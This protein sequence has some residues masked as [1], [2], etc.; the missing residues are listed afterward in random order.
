MDLGFNWSVFLT[1]F[2][3]HTLEHGFTKDLKLKSSLKKKG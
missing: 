1:N 3:L 2:V